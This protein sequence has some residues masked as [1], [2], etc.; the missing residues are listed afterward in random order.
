MSTRSTTKLIARNIVGFSTAF[1]V[2][3][4]IGNNTTP[5]NKVQQAEVYVAAAAC[6]MIV[7]DVAAAK[8]DEFVDK[9][10]DVLEGKADPKIVVI[11]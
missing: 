5:K 7:S 10:F 11:H 2:G 1:A 3:N 9:I 8:T 6:G 4:I